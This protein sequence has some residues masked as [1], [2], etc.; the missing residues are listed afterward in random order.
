[1]YLASTPTF[2]SAIGARAGAIEGSVI[3][4]AHS[5]YESASASASDARMAEAEAET[6]AI[7]G[8][9][10]QSH[11]PAHIPYLSQVTTWN[12]A[13]IERTMENAQR[14]EDEAAQMQ[15]LIRMQQMQQQSH[16]AS[17]SASAF[18]STSDMD[19]S[20]STSTTV[21]AVNAVNAVVDD[22]M[23]LQ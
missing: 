22:D 21:E 12:W 15:M 16:A 2:A 18:A 5:A 13:E 17:A 6:I 14:E 19:T 10:S 23:E 9:A 7:E 20:T 8:R 11:M 3:L 1:M 4:P